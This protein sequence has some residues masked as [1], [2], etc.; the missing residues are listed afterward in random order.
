MNN[1]KIKIS[2]LKVAIVLQSMNIGG[3]EMMAARLATYI[4]TTKF[5][6]KLFIISKKLNNQI[7]DIHKE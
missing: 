1:K 2:K 4:D 7:L 5:D 6:I 3:G